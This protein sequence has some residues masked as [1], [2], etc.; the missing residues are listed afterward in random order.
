M[1]RTTTRLGWSAGIAVLSLVIA[2]SV[3]TSAVAASPQATPT[4]TPKATASPTPTPTPTRTATPTPKPT[5]TP[6]PT[7]TPTSKTFTTAPRP[8]IS[9]TVRFGSTL[10]AKPGTWKPT[11]TLT[12]Q[13]RL[14]GTA[15]KGAT[16][17]T[18]TLP[19]S[20]VG[21]TVTVSV[22]GK[23]TGYTTKTMTS[24][25]TAKVAAATL[26][27]ATPKISGQPSVG[28]VLTATP[29][30]WGPTPVVLG[31]QWLRSGV[32]ISGATARTY[33]PTTA[34]RDK[35]ISVRVT[36]KKSGYA[37]ASRTSA[38]VTIGLP[39]VTASPATISGTPDVGKKLTAKVGAWDPRDATLTHQWYRGSTPITGATA[40]TYTLV[41][42]DAGQRLTVRTTGTKK[43]YT[44]TTVISSVVT[45]RKILTVPSSISQTGTPTVGSTLTA[46]AGSWGPSPVTLR[47]RWLRDGEPIAGATSK[48]Y[49]LTDADGGTAISVRIAG[50]KSGYT[51]AS[52]TSRSVAVKWTFSTTPTPSVTGTASSG[53]TLTATTGS[54]KPTPTLRYQWRVDGKAIAGATQATWSVPTWAAGRTISVS[55]TASKADYVTVTKTSSTRTVSKSLGST[56]R[57]GTSL[58]VGTYVA[59]SDGVYRFGPLGDGNVAVTQSGV[60]L[61]TSRTTGTIDPL[62]QFTADGD[63]VLFDGDGTIVW[64][65]GTAGSG[66]DTLSLAKDGIL[67]LR[68]PDGTVVWTSAKMAAF[69]DS[70][71]ATASTPG[72]YGWA[73]PIR[74]NGTFTTYSGHSGDDIAAAKGTPIYAMR[75]G[76]VTTRKIK[77]VSG[78][79]SWAPNDTL[80]WEVEITST[81]DGTKFVQVYAHLSK[82]SVSN[83]ATVKAGQKI[84]EV[85][86]TGC[87]TGPH[88]HTAFTVDGVRYALYPRDVLGVSSY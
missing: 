63:L 5:A 12:Y 8:T 87:S 9:G 57:P 4:A 50:S 74:P 2:M 69:A 77:I 44:K 18:W 32:A 41:R 31:Y 73:Y 21:K 78:C 37:S 29:G 20:A 53:R 88:L 60:P 3:G 70:T 62:L 84:G 17:S 26:T 56:I 43:G 40:L 81:I 80:Q 54:W 16:K 68:T 82:F 38:A 14:S 10:T 47:Y 36:A 64:T 33:T 23:R 15:V 19:A 55:V 51:S 28:R 22:T 65:S 42:A 13:W 45:V 79:P 27:P 71:A 1:G 39:F 6:T 7:P 72:R 58:R 66:A 85:G 67:S 59:S 35:P 48:T 34:D 75:G 30:A 46:V 61:R 11:A 86:S 83:G 24:S 52:R 25:A 76:K 49:K